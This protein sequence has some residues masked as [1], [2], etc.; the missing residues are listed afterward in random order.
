MRS[1]IPC[2]TFTKLTVHRLLSL[3][4]GLSVA[5][6]FYLLQCQPTPHI[7]CRWDWRTR[8]RA[9]QWKTVLDTKIRGTHCSLL[10]K[11]LGPTIVKRFSINDFKYGGAMGWRQPL[12]QR[13][14][15]LGFSVATPRVTLREEGG[16]L[17]FCLHLGQYNIDTF[18]IWN[19]HMTFK[20]TKEMTKMEWFH[21]AAQQ[22][23]KVNS[24]FWLLCKT[25]EIKW[26]EGTAHMRK[27]TD[28][29]KHLSSA[30]CAIRSSKTERV[31]VA[32]DKPF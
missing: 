5:L 31:K 26:P 9:T 16:V 32:Y 7:M 14:L 6:L 18:I 12:P 19:N 29:V 13:W 30:I 20:P 28:R 25:S 22:N 3:C 27:L 24:S 21:S 8:K 11:V 23:H 1:L 4:L 15:S 10:V 2:L 17:F